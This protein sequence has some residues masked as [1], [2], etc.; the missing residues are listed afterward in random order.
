MLA[1]KLTMSDNSEVLSLLPLT[2]MLQAVYGTDLQL[3]GQMKEPVLR[4]SVS[5]E[6]NQFIY[7]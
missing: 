4:R 1:N 3:F 5:G 7:F 6:Q 2:L